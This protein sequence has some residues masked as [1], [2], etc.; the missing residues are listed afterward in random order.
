[1]QPTSSDP[2]TLVYAKLFIT[3]IHYSPPSQNLNHTIDLN[4]HPISKVEV[5]GIVVELR[6]YAEKS[7][8]TIDDSTGSLVCNFWP[9]TTAQFPQLKNAP[10]LHALQESIELGCL[11]TVYGKLHIF[12]DKSY[13]PTRELNAHHLKIEDDEHAE[14]LHWLE[15]IHLY[16]NVYSKNP[17]FENSSQFK[18]SKAIKDL[19]QFNPT[20]KDSLD[21]LPPSQP[22]FTADDL[23]KNKDV[24][25]AVEEHIKEP[26]NKHST[27]EIEITKF[28]NN[29]VQNG[30]LLSVQDETCQN[31]NKP[32]YKVVSFE[33]L[34]PK[35]MEVIRSEYEKLPIKLYGVRDSHIF[36]ILRTQDNLSHLKM[37]HVILC[38]NELVLLGLIYALSDSEFKVVS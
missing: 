7:I 27:K 13:Q 12:T 31:S 11:V 18:L 30:D 9:A 2:L 15:C 33:I 8:L 6:H 10:N 35:V 21:L 32:L 34:G 25:A 4:G 20:T 29:L 24:A 23:L 36:K 1:M 19:L 17:P 28:L 37:N 22:V 38:L 14:M 3:L 16:D 5:T 26:Q